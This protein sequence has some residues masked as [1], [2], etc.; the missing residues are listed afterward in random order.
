MLPCKTF[1]S[2]FE[3]EEIVLHCWPIVTMVYVGMTIPSAPLRN[4]QY[5]VHVDLKTGNSHWASMKPD[6]GESQ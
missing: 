3:F 6:S 5:V 4:F 2:S 1:F